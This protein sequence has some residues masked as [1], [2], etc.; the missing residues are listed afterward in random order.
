[1][2]TRYDLTVALTYYEP[3]ISGL[4]HTARCVAEGMVE[5]GWRVAVVAAQ[6]EPDLPRRESIAGVDVYRSPVLMRVNRGFVAPGYPALAGRLARRSRV[7]LLNLP[8]AEAALVAA[9]RGRTPLV[10]MVHID[11]YLPP[12]R[13][14]RALMHVSNRA[15]LAAIR[16]S[17]AVVAYSEDQ[18]HASQL[19][20][21]MRARN[22]TPIAAPCLDRRHGRPRYRETGALHVGFLGRIVEEKGIQ[23]LVRAFRRIT[24]PRARLLVA[25]N[26]HSVAGGSNLADVQAEIAEDSRIRLLGELRGKEVDDFYASIDVFALPSVAESFGIVQAEAMMC[27][28]PSVTTDLPGGRYP[29]ASTGFGRVIPPRDPHALRRAILELAATTRQW[30]ETKAREARERFSVASC[31]DTYEALFTSLRAPA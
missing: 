9:A 6:H 7:L 1:M 13:F 24:D 4:T 18:A 20:P 11:L 14:S 21:A 17:A 8:M 12:G 15:S 30:R 26:Y 28:I 31:L 3:Y 29:V 27:G 16:R 5:R 23:Y 10:S 19:W 25:G 2:D 22:F